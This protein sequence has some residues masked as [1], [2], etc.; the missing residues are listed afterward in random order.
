[1]VDRVLSI[2]DST[3]RRS[4]PA[5]PKSVLWIGLGLVA[6]ASMILAATFLFG[7]L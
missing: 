7:L 4:L 1:M 6:W 5:L 2:L 3:M